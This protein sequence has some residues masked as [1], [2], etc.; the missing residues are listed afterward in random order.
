MKSESGCSLEM[1]GQPF[2][3]NMK[4]ICH[5]KE[6][7]DRSWDLIILLTILP[8]YL[9]IWITWWKCES[10][11]DIFCHGIYRTELTQN[12]SC[13]NKPLDLREA[14]CLYCITFCN[15]GRNAWR[16]HGP[17]MVWGWFCDCGTHTTHHESDTHLAASLWGLWSDRWVTLRT[18]ALIL[19]L[20]EGHM[21]EWFSNIFWV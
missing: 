21:M 11:R 19:P 5:R 17:P 7:W 13:F 4:N 15:G 8:L 3:F 16:G 2:W 1:A 20:E 12:S 18:S 10:M 6:H 14:D 9:I